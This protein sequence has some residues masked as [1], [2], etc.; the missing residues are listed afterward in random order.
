ME[1]I[2]KFLFDN[3]DLKYKEFNSKLI[4]NINKDKIIGVRIP[5]LRKYAKEI[6]LC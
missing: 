2:D 4:P 1:I 6:I 5:L 3:Q